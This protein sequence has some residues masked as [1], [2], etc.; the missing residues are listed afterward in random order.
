MGIRVQKRLGYGLTGVTQQDPRVNWEYD[1]GR[2]RSA[3][4]YFRWLDGRYGL[5]EGKPFPS[6][7]WLTLR[8]E[9][10]FLKRDVTKCASWDY[11]SSSPFPLVVRPLCYPEWSRSDDS[12][13]YSADQLR[14]DMGSPRCERLAAGIFP[15]DGQLMDAETG[16]RLPKEALTWRQVTRSPGGRPSAGKDERLSHISALELFTRDLLPQYPDY[17]TAV[18]R[19]VSLVPQE[20]RD[21]C[22]FLELFTGKDTWKQLRPV[23]ATWWG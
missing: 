19:V 3:L 23:L 15:F 10:R 12:I 4:S 1:K 14:D 13:D 18:A 21:V 16:E 7:D 11:E 6:M 9:P 5:G 2:H 20:I 17:Q 8:H 22:E